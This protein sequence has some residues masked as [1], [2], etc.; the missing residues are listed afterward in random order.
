M[1]ALIGGFLRRGHIVFDNLLFI[2][3]MVVIIVSIS[4]LCGLIMITSLLHEDLSTGGLSNE[5]VFEGCVKWGKVQIL[6]LELSILDLTLVMLLSLT[7]VNLH[8]KNGSA[9]LESSKNYWFEGQI[10]ARD[11]NETVCFETTSMVNT[12]TE[13]DLINI[14]DVGLLHQK[15]NNI[16]HGNLGKGKLLKNIENRMYIPWRRPRDT[17]IYLYGYL[18]EILNIVIYNVLYLSKSMQEYDSIHGGKIREEANALINLR[19][20]ENY[21]NRRRYMIYKPI[22]QVGKKL[23][24]LS[25]RENYKISKRYYS[26]IKEESELT[27]TQIKRM[28]TD[29][30]MITWPDNKT[31]SF[32]QREVFKKQ[33]ELVSLADIYGL[34]SE[35]VYKQQ[36]LLVNSIFFRIIAIDKLSK[37]AGSKTPGINKVCLT[38]KK[39][40]VKLYVELVE[41]L[42]NTLG[43]PDLYKS[44]PI[45]RVWIPK[46][47]GKQRPLGIPTLHDR[48]LQHL[49]NLVLEPLVEKTGELHSYGFRPNKSTKNAIAY[50]RSQLKTLDTDKI[51]SNTSDSNIINNVFKQ[52]SE[53]KWILDADIKGFFDNINHQ[54]LLDNLFLHPDLIKF[55]K[56]WLKSGVIDK[57][58]FSEIEMGTPQGGIISPTLANFTLN[59][60]ENAIMDSL[61]FLTKSKEKRIFVKLK[62]GSNTRLASGLAYVRYADD[63]IVLARSKHII[64]TYVLPAINEFLKLRGLALSPDKTKLFRLKEDNQQLDFLGYTFKYQEKWSIKKHMFYTHHAGS[65]GIALYPNKVKVLAFIDKIK[66]VF[67]RSQNLDAYNLIA[68]LNPML[69]GWSNYYNIGN[70]SHYRDT[71]RNATYHLIWKWVHNKHRRWGK[72]LIAKIYFLTIN[73]SSARKEKNYDYTKIKNVKWVFNGKTTVP[74]RYGNNEKRIYLVDVGTIAQ[75]LSSKHYVIPKQLLHIHAY[76]P[77]YMKVIEFNTNNNFKTLGINSS[78]KERLLKKQ[79]NLCTHCEKPLLASEGIYEGLHIHHI[80]PIFK[81]GSRNKIDNMVLLHSWCHNEIDHRNE[82]VNLKSNV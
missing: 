12:V 4:S 14:H 7:K 6:S 22:V 49:V 23:N 51:K 10:N 60:L 65:R 17:V 66:N 1:P 80:N 21:I 70:S 29:N 67:V 61:I 5:I 19:D 13:E 27:L 34:H 63:F 40:D 31:L 33:M 75:L 37:S 55:I 56:S 2:T 54:W 79:N 45:R 8:Y 15:E 71:V 50:L 46:A 43:N 35:K 53:S 52:T 73:D 11:I 82:G 74:S 38:S 39:E 42:R 58:V 57:E 30:D 16:K 62:D 77:D 36:L 32:I 68:K 81:G 41:W 47:N 44:D 3:F 9:I 78:F 76:H 26:I 59:G 24:S 72:K 25:L 69:R 18:I 64:N 20:T 28:L 48:A